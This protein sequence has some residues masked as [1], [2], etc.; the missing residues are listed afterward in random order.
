LLT[1]AAVNDGSGNGGLCQQRLS[2]ME[3]AVGW[4]DD[5]AWQRWR[6]WPMV[7]A[8]MAEFIVNCVAAVD[9]AATI[10]SSTLMAAA[11]SPSLPPP[12]TAASIND[13][14]YHRR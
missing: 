3:V 1:E 10:P 7:V 2:L 8:A 12:S 5:D 14:R 9:A 13:D 11:K 6:L 4:K